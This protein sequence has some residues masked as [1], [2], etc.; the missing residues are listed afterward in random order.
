MTETTG[1]ADT[2]L[3]SA[4]ELAE[5]MDI[6]VTEWTAQRTA[7]SMPVEGNRQ[8][9][10]LLHGG[11]S[12]VLAETLGSL[13]AAQLAPE[14]KVPVGTDLNCTHHRAMTT[15]TVHGVS[16]V[17][18]AGRSMASFEIVL[19]DEAG[20]RVCTSRLS[21]AFIEARGPVPPLG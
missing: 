19:V 13:H 2:I 8:P 15:G 10:G 11:A 9:Y 14:G 7:G 21:C 1:P 20:R 12:A 3:R 5:K 16:T 17:A 4:G 6:T 18:H